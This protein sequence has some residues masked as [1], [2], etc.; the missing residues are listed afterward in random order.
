MGR[1][2]F[3]PRTPRFGASGRE[4]SRI[5]AGIGSRAARRPAETAAIVLAGT[6]A[7]L[8]RIPQVDITEVGTAVVLGV[9]VDTLIVRTILVPT[10]LLTI[11]EQVWWPSRRPAQSGHG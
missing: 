2:A 4:G 11:G 7:A 10:A 6:F 8:T 1:A 9:L 3:W 5:W